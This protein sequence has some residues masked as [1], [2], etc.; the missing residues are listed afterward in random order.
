MN[1]FQPTQIA[2]FCKRPSLAFFESSI[3]KTAWI[4]LTPKKSELLPYEITKEAISSDELA[5]ISDVMTG[6]AL[7]ENMK[8]ASNLKT[9][10]RYSPKDMHADL[11][12][13]AKTGELIFEEIPSIKTIKG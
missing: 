3:P 8:L 9:A 10:D 2:P 1:N 11:E 12:N 13:L 6:W 5:E 4:I 7:K